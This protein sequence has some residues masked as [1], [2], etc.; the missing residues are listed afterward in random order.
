MP[1][2][3]RQSVPLMTIEWGRLFLEEAHQ[4]RNA[5]T[6]TF[7]AVQFLKARRRWA[8]TGTPFIND[9]TDI[10]SLLKFLRSKPWCVDA[11][12]HY[13]SIKP[14]KDRTSSEL[15]MD[16]PNQILVVGF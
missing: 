4:A 8:I 11:I 15:L 9:Y 1:E 7:K 16:L 6:D 10:H 14:K 5:K 2:V 3:T 13:Y 12:R